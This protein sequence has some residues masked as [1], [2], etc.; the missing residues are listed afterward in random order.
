MS[1]ND[2]KQH[3]LDIIEAVKRSDVDEK[4]SKT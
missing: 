1:N 4:D 3:D 2:Q